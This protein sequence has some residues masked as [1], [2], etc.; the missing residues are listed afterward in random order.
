MQESSGTQCVGPEVPYTA[1]ELRQHRFHVGKQVAKEPRKARDLGDVNR[2][3]WLAYTPSGPSYKDSPKKEMSFRGPTNKRLR[4]TTKSRVHFLCHACKGQDSRFLS[5]T[6][7]RRI[8][9]TARA[10]LE[11]GHP[12]CED[13]QRQ[14]STR[15]RPRLA[16][17]S[18]T[19]SCG[20][21]GSPHTIM[22]PRLMV[23]T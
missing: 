9:Y 17:D 16:S 7:P 11:T 14:R 1:P 3:Q 18:C 13:W 15:N 21:A 5:W 10:N 8:L 23:S 12:D 6:R 19:G 2:E 22:L 20:E 4:V